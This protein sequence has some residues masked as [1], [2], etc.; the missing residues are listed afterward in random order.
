MSFGEGATLMRAD[1]N[2]TITEGQCPPGEHQ[3]PIDLAKHA[4]LTDLPDLRFEYADSD[5]HIVNTG[6]TIQY[7]YAPGSKLIVGEREYELRQFHFHAHSE[8]AIDGKVEPMELHL[9]HA[10]TENPDELLVV[11]VRLRTG[12]EN[13]TLEQARWSDLPSD[14]AEEPLI[15]HDT[16]FNAGELLPGGPTYRYTGS[17]TAPPCFGNVSW[18]VFR[19][20][21]SLSRAQIA[22][23]T[24][25]YPDNLRPL[26]PLD[27]RA[28]QF[29]F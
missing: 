2:V 1:R 16:T 25:L 18:I 19:R 11:G 13:A 12:H 26:Q 29:G 3:S 7:S 14:E 8:H 15:D 17:L 27:G 21:L 23:F 9:V 22:R 6:G 10:S 5:L 4:C 20:S 24:A 28:V